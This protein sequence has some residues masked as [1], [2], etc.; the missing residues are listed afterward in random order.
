MCGHSAV[1]GGPEEHEERKAS[2]VPET[3][4]GG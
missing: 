1:G 4:L 2:Q 3:Q